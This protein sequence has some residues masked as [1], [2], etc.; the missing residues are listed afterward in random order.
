MSNW[1]Y[2]DGTN[3][4]VARTNADGSSESCLTTEISEWLSEGNTPEPANAPPVP[5]PK[6]TIQAQISSLETQQL[7]PRITRE[8]MLL[9]MEA[10]FTPEQLAGNYG[11]TKLKEFDTL[12]AILRAQL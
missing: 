7:L 3:R 4:V 2:T 1:K 11:Y 5:D 6:L 9:T 12:L 10:S 8:F